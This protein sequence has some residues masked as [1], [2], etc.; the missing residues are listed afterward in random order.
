MTS[1]ALNKANVSQ[2]VFF[3]VELP[4]TAFITNFSMSIDNQTYMGEIKEKEKAKKEYE[5]AVSAGKMAGLVKASGRKMEKFS[6]S[7]NIAANS[8]VTF[9]LMYEELLQ[10]RLGKYELIIRVKPKQLVQHFEIVADIYEPQGITFLDTN[11]TFITNDLLPLVSKSVTDKKA[12]VSFSPTLDQQR[13]CPHCDATL[14]DGDFIITY[15]VNRT[16]N[17]GDI[18]I[19]NGYFVHFFAPADLP[20]LPKNVV[21]VIDRSGS[22]EGRKMVQTREALLTVLDDLHEEDHF[23]LVMFDDHIETWRPSLSK[24]TQENKKEAQEFVKDITARHM[25]DIN[26]AVLHAVHMLATAKKNDSLPDNSASMIILLTD[27][28]P[29]T[30][31]INI[32][33]IQDNVRNAISGNMTLFCL[34]FGADVDYPFLDVLAK[35]NDGLARRIYEASDALLQLQ[36]FYEEVASPLLLEVS[37]HYPD[38]VATSLTNNHFRQLFNGS[39]IVVAG[40]LHD[41][42]VENVLI[43]VSAQALD[44]H[45]SIQGQAPTEEWTIMFPEQDYIFGDFTERLWAY[46]TIQ[47][48]LDKRDKCAPNDRENITAE[49]LDLSLRYNFVT[50]LTSL[51]VT[52]P[53]TDEKP[54]DPLI[55][56]KLTEDQRINRIPTAQHFGNMAFG[57]P[58]SISGPIPFRGMGGVSAK[59]RFIAVDGDPHFIIELPDQDD[60]LCFNTNDQPGT[61][62]NLVT[63]PLTGLV[64]NGQTIGDKMV[65]PGS[66]QHTYFG[67]FGILHKTFGIKLTV[68]TQKVLV[69]EQGKQ[70]QLLWS[71]TA[72]I[73]SPNMNLQLTKDRLTV[74]LRNSLKLVIIL[75]KVW[76]SHPD[77]QDYLGFYTLDSH[78]VSQKVHG[79]IGQFYH[80]VTFE[81]SDVFQ[82]KDPDKPDATMFVKGH[83]LTVTR[84]WQRDFRRDVKNGENVPC[85]F[86]HNNGAGL[87]DGALTDYIV[88][89]LFNTT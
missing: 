19:V 77:H 69:S 35:Q 51:V 12:H 43:E 83:K 56:D 80:G 73:K 3:E 70:E 33:V 48:L 76:K 17:I 27:G 55:A 31:E 85:W 22:M 42:E 34:G 45:I 88:S 23:G 52:K 64:I 4:K 9:T 15:D 13:K 89:D 26:E 21:F 81:V 10:R 25:T 8:S 58:L 37:L 20:Q 24:A 46:L 28:E 29:T 66:Q 47:Q 36:D 44:D 72:T 41:F 61:I 84:G 38:S 54:E 86:I 59:L 87:I 60:A 71:K 78:L 63:D 62:F 53:E 11:V 50:P 74:T 2:E 7:V 40:Q 79:L 75:H 65:Q 57:A 82:G 39:E 16:E 1:T 67:Q 6:V 68:T 18:Q 30:G 49:A 5:T 14:I 32:S